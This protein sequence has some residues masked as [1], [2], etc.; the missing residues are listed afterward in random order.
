MIQ[1]S[2]VRS[3]STLV[4]NILKNIFKKKIIKKHNINNVDKNV[5]ITYRNP[6]DSLASLI[7]IDNPNIIPLQVD[8]SLLM[9]K[10]IELRKNGLDDIIK[11]FNNPQPLFLKYEDFKN[12]Y[13]YIYEN[14]SSHFMIEI[15]QDK[16]DYINDK[17]SLL[18]VK[19]LIDRHKSF[20]EWDKTTQLHGNHISKY[21]GESYFKDFFNEKQMEKIKEVLNKHIEILG[22]SE[23]IYFN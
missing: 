2:P 9:D 7:L 3:G 1:F 6:L 5:V 18:N 21:N 19:N 10:L 12:N 13:N 23:E 8:D 15:D 4:Y 11:I 20:K 22:Y 17:F 14:I 16:R